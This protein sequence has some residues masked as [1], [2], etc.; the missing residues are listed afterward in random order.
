MFFS[1]LDRHTHGGSHAR[2]CSE[3]NGNF[4]V[5]IYTDAGISCPYHARFRYFYTMW[6]LSTKS[7]ASKCDLCAFLSRLSAGGE[8]GC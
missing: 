2:P 4:R 5:T 7:A 6:Y 8:A 1:A 3:S